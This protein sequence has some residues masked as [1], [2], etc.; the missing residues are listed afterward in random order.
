MKLGQQLNKL[1]QLATA[2]EQEDDLEKSLAIFEESV[3]VA[4]DCVKQLN[5]CKGKLIVLQDKVKE[6]TDGDKD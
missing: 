3:T 1:E 6:I 2:I 5:D 4:A